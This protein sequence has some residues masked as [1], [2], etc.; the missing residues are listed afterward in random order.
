MYPIGF[1]FGL[2]F[3]TASEVGLLAMTAGASA[4]NLPVPAVLCLPILFAAGMSMMDTTDGILMCK[5]YNWVFINPL[6]KI[7]YFI[8]A[9]GLSVGA[10]ISLPDSGHFRLIL[11]VLAAARGS[12]IPRLLGLV[13]LR[14]V[15]QT[16]L[17]KSLRNH[18][19]ARPSVACGARSITGL[20]SFASLLIFFCSR[21]V[22][23]AYFVNSFSLNDPGREFF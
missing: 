6:R 18:V 19:V 7:F 15:S 10:A 17:A 21:T 8:L 2:G 13:I 20:A 12:L 4:G 22:V 3:D 1:L 16:E 5:A 11:L 23:L 9:W 14:I